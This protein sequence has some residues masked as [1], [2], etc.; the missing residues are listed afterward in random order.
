MAGLEEGLGGLEGA[1]LDGWL[2]LLVPEDLDEGGD[3]RV[4]PIA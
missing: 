2:F 3:G 4:G 1:A